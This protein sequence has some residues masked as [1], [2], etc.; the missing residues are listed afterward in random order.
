MQ[1]DRWHAVG[2][3]HRQ[4]ERIGRGIGFK[5]RVEFLLVDESVS[6]ELVNQLKDVARA[7]QPDLFD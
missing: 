1:R 6:D 7:A 3:D 5:P 4:L 2:A